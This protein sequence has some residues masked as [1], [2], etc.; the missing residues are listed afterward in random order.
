MRDTS[1]KGEKETYYYYHI[2]K[3]VGNRWG[4][5]RDICA[6]EY[7]KSEHDIAYNSAITL[8]DAKQ[9]AGKSKGSYVML[10]TDT[11]EIV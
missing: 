4:L 3:V 2:N 8:A 7:L 1:K 6:R 5:Q 9:L 10:V 11:R